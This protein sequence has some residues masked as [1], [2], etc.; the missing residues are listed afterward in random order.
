MFLILCTSYVQIFKKHV[1]SYVNNH[2]AFVNLHYHFYS[3]KPKRKLVNNVFFVLPCVIY[4]LDNL[5]LFLESYEVFY[6]FPLIINKCY[7]ECIFNNKMFHSPDV[8]FRK[9]SIEDN[10]IYDS[11]QHVSRHH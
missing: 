11:S 2:F 9:Q 10:R 6:L 4:H 1:C 8:Y 3:T 5:H 7:N